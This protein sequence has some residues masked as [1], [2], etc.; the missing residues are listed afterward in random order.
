MF[1]SVHAEEIC[2][3]SLH[4]LLLF[5][6]PRKERVNTHIRTE[7]ISDEC[8]R[9]SHCDSAFR[10]FQP[11][12]PVTARP[13]PSWQKRNVGLDKLHRFKSN[14]GITHLTDHCGWYVDAFPCFVV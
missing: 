4:Y 9:E 6:G 11:E 1:V 10:S 12:L 7:V 2:F 8:I 13:S 5:F 3:L 14:I